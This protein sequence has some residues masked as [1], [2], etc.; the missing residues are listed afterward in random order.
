MDQSPFV[1]TLARHGI[2]PPRR[3]RVTTLQVNVGRR[4]DL[5]C[6]HCH[7]EA[8]PKRTEIMQ[9]ETAERVLELLAENPGVTTLDLTGGA[10]E[11]NEQ[12][13]RLVSGARALGRLVIDRCNLTVLFEAGQETTAEFMAQSGVR[14]VASLPCYTKKNVAKQRGR[15]TFDKSIR[16]LRDLNRLGY[17][18]PGSPLLLD[19]VY[20]PLGA[21]LP[22]S[23]KELEERYRIELNERFGIDFHR[24]LTIA[25]MPIKRFGHTL[26]R[27]EK[28]EE[29]LSLLI[30]SFNPETVSGLMC[31][32]LVSVA[33]DGRL[34]D[35][36][37]NQMLE[38][39][40]GAG[41]R[42]IWEI[43]KLDELEGAPIA[44]D[45]H[46][47]GCAAGAGSSCTGALR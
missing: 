22:P 47:H 4:C 26:E 20:N 10:P 6:H 28:R 41:S 37:F 35:C 33:Y 46:C 34:Y 16:A 43:S 45:E 39:P 2:D 38:R 9:A 15:D 21:V 31:R 17:G 8:G 24:L 42:T 27:D 18:L 40:M 32:S 7:V 11:L 30:D 1:E 25:N 13:R 19:L 12:F 29:Y 44:T 36:D 14:I 5:A 3:A 23:Q